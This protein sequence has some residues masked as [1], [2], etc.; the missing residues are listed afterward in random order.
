M[1]IKVPDNLPALETLTS[2]GVELITEGLAERQDIRPLRLLLLNLMP[3]K[4]DTEIQFARLLGS[5]PLQVDLLLMTTASYTPRNTEPAYLRR[6]YRRLEDV[7]DQHF[8][9]LIVTGAPIETLPFEDVDYWPELTKILDWSRDHCFRRLGICW[10]A[11]ALMKHF[12]QLEKYQMKEKL[13]GVYNHQLP[14]SPSR[15]M[16]GFTDVF[17][18]PVSRYTYNP[19]DE[20]KE[21]GLSILAQSKEAGVGM[22][23]CKESGDLYVLNH[24]EYDAGTLGNEYHRDKAEKKNTALPVNYFPDDHPDKEPVNSWRPFAYLLMSNWLNDLYRC[25][26]FD[27]EG[28]GKAK[29]P[30]KNAPK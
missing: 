29:E 18:M 11:Q 5:S 13:F 24:L 15:L 22:A 1:P 4:R 3:K 8:D 30:V 23:L 19:E 14:A 21:A 27:L 16:Q 9:A 20:L 2:E 10:G 6:F 7:E 12:H 17:P 28:S 25:T 26:N